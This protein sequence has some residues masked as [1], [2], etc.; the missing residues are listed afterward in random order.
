MKKLTLIAATACLLF[1]CKK[2]DSNGGVT[3]N[4]DYFI[5]GVSGGLCYECYA[6][7]KIENGKIYRDSI[8][9]TNGPIFHKVPLPAD[10]C[11]LALSLINNFP[12]YLLAHP[13][14][15]YGCS[16]CADQRTFMIELSQNG[17]VTEWSADDEPSVQPV[18]IKAYLQQ[19]DAIINQ[20]GQ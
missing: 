1:S 8:I 10:K 16:G 11:N 13:N 6:T 3:L 5:F 7:Y 19:M 15:H 20:L 17:A 14:A 12:K 18:Q 2:N 9:F 4:P